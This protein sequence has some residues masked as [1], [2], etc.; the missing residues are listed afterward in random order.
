MEKTIL[1]KSE[2]RKANSVWVRF[3][4]LTFVN[5]LKSIGVLP[6][7]RDAVI[8]FVHRGLGRQGLLWRGSFPGWRFRPVN[9]IVGRLTMEK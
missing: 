8:G 4:K 9:S 3:A 2:F 7:T 6:D 5:T 1:F